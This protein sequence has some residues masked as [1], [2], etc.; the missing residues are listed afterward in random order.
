M[1]WD[2]LAEQW[3]KNYAALR[4]FY[5]REGHANVPRNYKTADGL[6]LGTWLS[7]QRKRYQAREWSE[8][9]R[10]AKRVSALSDEEVARLEA[11]GVRWR[12]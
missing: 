7:N 8:A 5:E 2:V 9:E 3:E 12:R 11:L 4:A 1:V 6:T 10:K